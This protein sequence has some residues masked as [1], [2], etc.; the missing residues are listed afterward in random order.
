MYAL[1]TSLA[2]VNFPYLDILEWNEEYIMLNY[3]K[4]DLPI[5][6]EL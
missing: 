5:Y 2:A 3:M 4:I 1:D 6:N